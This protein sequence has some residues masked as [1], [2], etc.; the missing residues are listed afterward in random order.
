MPHKPGDGEVLNHD[1]IDNALFL[2]AGLLDATASGPFSLVVCGGAALAITGLFVRTTKDVDILALRDPA[3][4]SLTSPEPLPH[5]LL[6]AA[7][8]A[9]K[10]MRLP[11]DWLNNGPS[12]NEGGLFQMGLPEG[13]A[14]RLTER[15]YGKRLTVFFISRLDQIHFK[16]YAAVDQGGGYHAADL[17]HLKPT[18][19]EIKCAARWT[20]THDVSEVFH[21]ELQRFLHALGYDDVAQRL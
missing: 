3:S 16:L 9:A 4:G 13:L 7:A 18:E 2:I 21:S 20:M 14:D 19:S 12:S 15:V 6:D 10:E 1:S 11:P 17:K 5:A 8:I